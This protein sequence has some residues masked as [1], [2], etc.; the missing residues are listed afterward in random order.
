[1]RTAEEGKLYGGGREEKGEE[2]E[3]RRKEKGEGE[4]A[5]KQRGIREYGEER[6]R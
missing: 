1:M 4:K 2:E 5:V 3:R 6:T